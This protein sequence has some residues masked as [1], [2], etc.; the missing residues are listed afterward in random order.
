MKK[1]FNEVNGKKA[2]CIFNPNN[3]RKKLNFKIKTRV[4][5]AVAL[6]F[7]LIAAFSAF[8][9]CAGCAGSNAANDK[10]SV[11]CTI[12]PQYDWAKQIING[13]NDE[14]GEPVINLS[15]LGGSGVDMHSYS[16]T[17]ADIATISKCNA[18]IYVGGESDDKW[19][20]NALKT[21]ANKNL[22][23][24]R[25]FDVLEGDLLCE[26]HTHEESGESEEHDHDHGAEACAYDEHVWLSIKNAQKAV[27]AICEKI[28]ALDSANAQEYTKNA[29]EYIQK[30]AALNED[31]ASAVQ[32]AT[33]K[34]LV[35]GDRFPFA[36]LCNDYGIAH[37]AAFSG[38]SAES[39]AS[40]ETIIKLANKVDEL[41]LPAIIKTEGASHAIAEKV[42]DNVTQVS[43]RIL[44]LDSMQSVTK[45]QIEGGFSYVS[46]C[47]ANLK[48]L[49]T[50]LGVI[51]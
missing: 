19:V 38:C 23:E 20:Q 28:C 2:N 32:K 45:S 7:S 13:V 25:L 16:P 26:E 5:K 46:A 22:I 14:N 43:P 8:A 42:K 35:F 11:V 1:G 3:N 49:K 9:A 41:G 34:T 47:E 27:N 4:L 10:I 17:V 51:E 29:Q 40:F 44:V 33:Y 12:F 48:I 36:Y 24:I 37:Y 31:Y 30:L 39:E 50:A 21:A 18:F 6:I 15:L